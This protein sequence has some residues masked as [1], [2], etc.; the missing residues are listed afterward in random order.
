MGIGIKTLGDGGFQFCKNGLICKVLEATGMKHYNG[1]PTPVKVEVPLGIDAN[2]SED[3]RDWPNS[4]DSVIGMML[5]MASNT[6]SDISF[7]VHQCSWL[8]ITPR[9]NTRYL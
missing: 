1:L 9:N 6:R 8:K 7:A 3:K 5:Y 2:G 4:C